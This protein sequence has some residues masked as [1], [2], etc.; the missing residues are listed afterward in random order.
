MGKVHAAIGDVVNYRGRQFIM[1]GGSVSKQR[2][3]SAIDFYSGVGGW[4][5]GLRLAGVEVVGSYEWWDKANTTNARNNHHPARE[6]DIRSLPLDSL[7]SRV[8]IVV[9]SPPCTQFSY[10]NRGGSG[11]IADGLKDI[12]RFFAVVDRVGPRRWAMEN[13]PRVAGIV[14][15]ELRRGGALAK[16]A[17]LRPSIMVVDACEWGVPQRRKRCII[18]NLDFDL[19]QSY[20]SV[21]RAVSL[22]DVVASLARRQVTDPVYGISIPRAALTEQEIEEPLSDEEERMNREMKTFHPVYNN[23]PFPDPLNRAAR[24]VTAV[25][26]RVSRESIVIAAPES[27]GKYRRLTLRERA[28]LQGFPITY[29]FFG[30]SHAQKLRMIGNAIPP[31]LVYFIAHALKETP[32]AKVPPLTKAIAAFRPPVSV[33]AVSPPESAGEKFPET[34]RFRAALPH[35]RF[36]SGV[37]FEL[38]NEFTGNRPSWAVRFF[39][40]NSKNITEVAL[41]KEMVAPLLTMV[42]NKAAIR[43]I[44]T[45]VH[46]AC[47]RTSPIALQRYWSHRETSGIHPYRVV[48][49]IGEAARE[50][51]ALLETDAAAAERAMEQ[52]LADVGTR[53]GFE[54]V[55]RHAPA[56]LTGLLVGA[57]ANAGFR[58]PKATPAKKPRREQCA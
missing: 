11:D 45:R 23:M 37:R 17:H 41:K 7:P 49:A 16:Y 22:G 51:I 35:L 30:D 25:C 44:I 47:A 9:G 56:I 21:A 40:G 54:K 26:T 38:S 8:D 29:Q 3:L 10:S 28:C 31:P 18:G 1:E 55:R 48:D 32:K 14:E 36:K 43:K 58:G 13:V 46:K 27:K 5:L 42:R 20:R 52:V 12:E 19:L 15:Q 53:P 50:V 39:F 57:S 2:P 34:R 24:T 6:C 4:S 33:P